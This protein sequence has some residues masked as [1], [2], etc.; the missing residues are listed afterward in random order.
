MMTLL[1]QPVK[2]LSAFDLF[3]PAEGCFTSRQQGASA[4]T[5]SKPVMSVFLDQHKRGKVDTEGVLTVVTFV[6]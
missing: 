2:H 4:G 5:V 6:G 3:Y 1:A